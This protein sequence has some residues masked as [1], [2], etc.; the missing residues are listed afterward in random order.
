M[1]TS[2]YGDYRLEETG[3]EAMVTGPYGWL[4][5]KG[6]VQRQACTDRRCDDGIRMDTRGDCPARVTMV[7]DLR[8]H[9][10]RLRVVVDS[11]CAD[12]DVARRCAVY[13]FRLREHTALEGG[14]TEARHARATIEVAQ[15]RAAADRRRQAEASAELARGSPPCA[16]C[17]L[18]D[19]A[20][21]CPQCTYRQR[22]DLLVQEAV[23]LAV[24]V[25]ADL[26]DSESV[27]ALSEHPAR[28]RPGPNA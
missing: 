14:Q 2:I 3:G 27:A 25:R 16:E 17:G 26:D 1:R 7:A 11:E 5:R 21:L 13:E 22:T 9:R 24:A 10:A 15:R 28:R 18:L 6:L 12:A 23:D 19:A 8:A 4:I 20:D